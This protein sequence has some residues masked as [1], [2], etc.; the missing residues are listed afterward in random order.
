MHERRFQ[1]EI[2]RLRAPQRVSLLEVDRVV[3]LCLDGNQANNVLD[4]GTGSGIFAEA[5]SSRGLSVTGIDPNPEMLKAAKEFVPTG[6]FLHGTI[7]EI[8]FKD[9]SFDIV[10]LGHV[11]HESDNM[12]KAL[13]EAKRVAKQKV[14]ILEW[15]YKQEES[16][17]PVEHR[18]KTDEILTAAKQVGFS[19][20]ETFQMQYMVFFK[21]T[22]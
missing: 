11:L 9:H 4:I 16:G 14:C 22:I 12:I 2:E 20:A 10:F 7:E 21:F 6:T 1:G 18:L 8:P 17:P 3:G 15:P 5:F 19:M 13:S